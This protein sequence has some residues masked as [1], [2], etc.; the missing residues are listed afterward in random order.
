MSKVCL[1]TEQMIVRKSLKEVVFY[2]KIGNL[3][4]VRET[5]ILFGCMSGKLW[6]NL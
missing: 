5:I 6:V 1:H 3:Y 2:R 4:A